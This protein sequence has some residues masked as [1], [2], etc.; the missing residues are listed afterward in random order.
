MLLVLALVIG[1]PESMRPVE[2]GP[3]PAASEVLAPMVKKVRENETGDN[4]EAANSIRVARLSGFHLGEVEIKAL[5]ESHPEEKAFRWRAIQ[6]TPDLLREYREPPKPPAPTEAD[7]RAAAAVQRALLLVEEIREAILAMAAQEERGVPLDAESEEVARFVD[8]VNRAYEGW[9]GRDI[10]S[11]ALRTLGLALDE[12]T[13]PVPRISGLREAMRGFYPDVAAKLSD[14][15][16]QEAVEAK[17]NK[18]QLWDEGANGRESTRK[19]QGAKRR[20]GAARSLVRE[21]I[22]DPPSDLR[23]AIQKLREIKNR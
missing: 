19:G 23:R 5:R 1:G 18:F 14:K 6:Q 9:R 21:F 16:I 4:T 13:K 22:K 8:M 7:L 2:L 12:V 20:E 15:A 11:L 3:S 17:R 10:Q